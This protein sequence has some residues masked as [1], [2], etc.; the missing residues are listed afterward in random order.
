MISHTDIH[1]HMHILYIYMS[2]IV[3]TCSACRPAENSAGAIR[4]VGSTE[5]ADGEWFGVEL[6]KPLG[7]NV[8]HFNHEHFA[9]A[10]KPSFKELLGGLTD[11]CNRIV[12]TKT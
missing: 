7:K 8:P 10:S 9:T 5:F 11:S 3:E 12:V 1:T 4:F 2:T 6:E